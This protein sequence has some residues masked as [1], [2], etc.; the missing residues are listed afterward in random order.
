MLTE[1]GEPLCITPLDSRPPGGFTREGGPSAGPGGVRPNSPVR[2]NLGRPASAPR[3]AARSLFPGKAQKGKV[4]DS[5]PYKR[6]TTGVIKPRRSPDN[7]PAEPRIVLGARTPTGR[8]KVLQSAPIPM[9]R[10]PEE[11]T[12]SSPV[13]KA[14]RR[15]LSPPRSQG[16]SG[17]YEESE[18]RVSPGPTISRLAAWSLISARRTGGSPRSSPRGSSSVSNCETSSTPFGRVCA[19][20]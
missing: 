3:S 14:V 15:R 6:P 13:G 5:S 9:D 17:H 11:S 2:P 18:E 20:R 7:S 10:E 16:P 12:E 8:G 4:R 19:L 1:Y